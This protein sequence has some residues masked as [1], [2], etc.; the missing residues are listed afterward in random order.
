MKLLN[1]KSGMRLIELHG[2]LNCG[3]NTSLRLVERLR[4]GKSSPDKTAATEKTAKNSV[5]TVTL[6]SLRLS[7]VEQPTSVIVHHRYKAA[8]AARKEM[9]KQAVLSPRVNVGGSFSN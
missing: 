6:I 4:R 8:P 2:H 9:R 3:G 7:F 5:T 1:F